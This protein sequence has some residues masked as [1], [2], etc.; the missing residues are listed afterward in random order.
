M[1]QPA[2]CRVASAYL[3][4]QAVGPVSPDQLLAAPLEDRNFKKICSLVKKG[5]QILVGAWKK[6]KLGF[7]TTVTPA[8]DKITLNLR[9]S[10]SFD[11]SKAYGDYDTRVSQ[12]RYVELS[13]NGTRIPLWSAFFKGASEEKSEAI[14]KRLGEKLELQF[15]IPS[16]LYMFPDPQ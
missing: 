10:H 2:I 13:W 9:S 11:S 8:G 7:Y 6:E 5:S 12:G 4:K 3:N 15:G 16:S 1:D 14:E